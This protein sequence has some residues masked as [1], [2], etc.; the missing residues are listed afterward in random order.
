MFLK[1]F[2]AVFFKFI[3]N[4]YKVCT[5]CDWASTVSTG[6]SSATRKKARACW[7]SGGA[8]NRRRSVIAR[9]PRRPPRPPR[10]P[11]PRQRG[12]AAALASRAHRTGRSPH[13]L[14]FGRPPRRSARISYSAA[15][16]GAFHVSCELGE[17]VLAIAISVER[18]EAAAAAARV[19]P[20]RLRRHP[21]ILLTVSTDFSNFASH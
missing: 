16:A 15:S 11:R 8:H 9:R 17:R 19:V 3:P 6:R 13:M 1:F 14:D 2:K 7:L 20:S 21:P 5:Y 12:H 10:P 4:T 18:R